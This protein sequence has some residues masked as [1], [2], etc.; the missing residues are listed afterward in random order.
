MNKTLESFIRDTL[1]GISNIPNENSNAH[2]FDFDCSELEN[3]LNGGR[4]ITKEPSKYKEYLERLDE[5]GVPAI[6]WFEIVSDTDCG[7]ILRIFEEYKKKKQRTTPA[8]NSNKNSKILYVGKVKNS[9]SGRLIQHLGYH[10]KP[11]DQG[12]Q[13]FHWTRELSN[14]LELKLHVIKIDNEMA[15]L[16]PALETY[17]ADELK[18]LIGMH[19]R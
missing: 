12:L 3:F 15:F 2:T 11:T 4:D 8:L 7:E 13:L 6:Y 18:P 5:I 9:L 19:V 16:I 1:R 10:E 17:F 14:K